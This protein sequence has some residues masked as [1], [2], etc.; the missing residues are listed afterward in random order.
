MVEFCILCMY[1]CTCVLWEPNLKVWQECMYV[2]MYVRTY[3]RTYVCMYVCMYVCASTYLLHCH[4]TV[5]NSGTKGDD[6]LLDDWLNDLN[7]AYPVKKV[8][9]YNHG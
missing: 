8:S 1:I 9:E 2:C 5:D 7:S 3:V 6:D 4:C